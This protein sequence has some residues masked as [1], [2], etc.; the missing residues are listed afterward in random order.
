MKFRGYLVCCVVVALQ[1]SSVLRA[2]QVA[3]ASSSAIVPRMVNF[4]G[5]ATDAQGKPISGA[6]GVTFAVYK[7]QSEGAPLWIE[8]Q[9]VTADAKGNYSVQLGATKPEGLPVDLFISG[10]ARWM[11]VRINGGEEQPRVLLLS[12]PYALKAADAQTLGGLPASA[13][14]LAAPS[15]GESSASTA[16]PDSAAT[17]Q[18]NLAGTGTVDYV[19]LWTPNGSTLGNSVLYQ[20]GSL[21]TAKIGIGTTAPATKLDVSGQATVRGT[22]TLPTTGNATASGGKSSQ[23]IKLSA[24]SF[25]SGSNTAVNQN[26]LWQAEPA[27]N[28]TANP[29]GTLNLLF[30]SGS[31]P[32]AQTG[33]KVSSNGHITFATGQVFPGSGTIK[34]V[35]AGLGLTGG[36]TSGNVTLGLDT[37][38]VPQLNSP[39]IFTQ[40][41]SVNAINSLGGVLNATSPYQAIVGT[42]TSNDFYTAAVTGNST[43]TGTGTTIGVGGFTSTSAGFGVWGD[44]SSSGTGVNG[45][46]SSGSGVSGSS[47]SGA[48]VS[49]KS[50]S[51]TGVSGTSASGGYG[52][53]GEAD[54]SGSAGIYGVGNNG[55]GVYGRG[56]TAGVWGTS[57]SGNAFYANGNAAQVRTGSGWVKAMVYVNGQDA[58]YAIERCYNSTLIGAAATTPPCGIEL[59][60]GTAAGLWGLLLNFEVDDRFVSATLVGG[61]ADCIVAGQNNA[62]LNYIVY[63]TTFDCS[64]KNNLK[65]GIFT[66]FIF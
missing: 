36:G 61:D 2:Q 25:N 48:G 55:V 24:S 63:M 16:A 54:N 41:I 14:V 1:W 7:D 12:V 6:V 58:P 26:F 21:S 50:T 28:N 10:D 53:Y 42:M 35:T 47:S 45:T 15:N 29:D 18:A 30:G 17:V 9:N 40:T 46:S 11:G 44:N 34:G 38:K 49:G 52:V 4:S 37:T 31:N 62:T 66:V 27:G 65:A 23:P 20:S 39:N 57:A 56:G 13:F 51:G 59:L 22:L 33:L 5:R 60:E 32:A 64:S 3:V 8:T 43:A 19:P